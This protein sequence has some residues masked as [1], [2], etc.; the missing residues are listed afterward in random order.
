MKRFIAL[1][2]AGWLTVT[3]SVHAA[4]AAAGDFPKALASYGD[5]PEK[6]LLETLIGRVQAEPFN[7][8]ATAIFVL[9]IIHTFLAS[10]FRHMAHEIEEAHAA[11][12]ANRKRAEDNNDDG[13]PDEVSFKGQILHFFGE[14]EAVFGIWVIVLMAALGFSKGW[15]TVVDYVGHRV[16]FTE[17]MF[18]VVIMALASTRP[19]LRVA[20]QCLRA[21]ASLGKGSVAAWWLA[22]LVIAPILGS[23]ITEP[24]AMTIAALLLARQFYELKPSPKFAYATLGLL[25]VNVSV[26]G[27]LTHFAAP[28][29][30]MVAATWKWDMA[31]M[32]THFGWKAVAG[33]VVATALYGVYFRK[34]LAGLNEAKRAAEA[35]KAKVAAEAPVPA[36]ITIVQ[37]GFMGFTVFVAHY[38]ALFVGGFLFF[39]AFS[40]ATAHHQGKLDLKP[41]LLVGFFLAGLV[42]HGGLQGWWIEPVLSRL[43]EMP[44]FLGATV[45]TAVNDNAA[46]TYLATLVP[47]FTDELKYAVV[48]GAVTGGGLTVIAN[49][50]NPAGQSILQRYFPSGVSPIGLLVGALIPTVI[51]GL[52]FMAL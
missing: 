19:V 32:F 50:P 25:F 13:R 17:P 52:A 30:L 22:I 18:V 24:A 40:Q 2:S 8:V 27:T 29:V 45:L 41:S 23:F 49:A 12:I 4:A 34:E 26:G 51:M 21:V 6:G 31:Y 16:N 1:I 48:A 42:V 28:P 37:L 5:G 39:L 36:W 47:G 43:G 14:V 10:K 20:E 35:G 11:K 9:A 15:G 46:I 3:G 38:P 33:I 7:A 44:L